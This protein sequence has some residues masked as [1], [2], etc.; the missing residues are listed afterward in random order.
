VDP[1]L[2]LQAADPVRLSTGVYMHVLIALPVLFALRELDLIGTPVAGAVALATGVVTVLAACL[3]FA[4]F[5]IPFRNAIGGTFDL[6]IGRRRTQS[7]VVRLAPG[8][9][10]AAMPLPVGIVPL[11]IARRRA[12]RDR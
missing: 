2:Q 12:W 3:C 8:C 9:A 10:P 7:A 4:W 11:A 1:R 6:V 5:E